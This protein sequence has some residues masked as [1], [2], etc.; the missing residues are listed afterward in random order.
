MNDKC[1]K[2]VRFDVKVR[3]NE[4]F[5]VFSDTHTSFLHYKSYIYDMHV[6]QSH[7]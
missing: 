4:D 1:L 3:R 2:S 7:P 6:A 5:R